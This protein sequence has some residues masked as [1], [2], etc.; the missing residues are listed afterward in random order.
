METHS[1]ISS[2]LKIPQVS[3]DGP[4]TYVIGHKNP[5]S[6]SVLSAISYTALLRQL[7]P[8]NFYVAAAAGPITA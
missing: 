4:T 5:D 8:Q 1:R 7:Y 3:T 2:N 6:D